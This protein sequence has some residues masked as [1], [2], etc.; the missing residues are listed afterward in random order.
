MSNADRIT[1]QFDG[2]S[3]PCVLENATEVHDALGQVLRGWRIDEVA[4]DAQQPVLTLRRSEIG[5]RIDGDWVQGSLAYTD[6]VDALCAFIAELVRAWVQ[7]NPE[8]LCLHGAAVELG[9]R[10]VVFPSTYRA[11]KSVLTGC[12]AA[13]GAVVYTDDVLPIDPVQGIAR[14]PGIVPRLRLPVPDVLDEPTRRSIDAHTV[15]RGKRY[16]YVDPGSG[17]LASHGAAARIGALVLLDRRPE[18]ETKL[19]PVGRNQILRQVIWQNFARAAPA[20]EILDA[21]HAIVAGAQCY[22]LRYSRADRA[23]ALL[24]DAASSWS[25]MAEPAPKKAGVARV[26]REGAK[27]PGGDDRVGCYRRAE[28]IHERRVDGECFLADEEGARIHHLNPIGSAIWHMLEEPASIDDLVGTLVEAFPEVK[29][30][31]LREDVSAFVSRI[32]ERG[33]LHASSESSRASK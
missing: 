16:A 33:L 13:A 24:M 15:V 18:T 9:E 27:A 25:P 6:P 21:L 20:P 30:E 12:L 5:Y 32:A 29:A 31:Q 4:G 23:A 22:R 7:P 8:L 2:L 19:L 10:L 17:L 1:L 14:A 11:G 26:R 3:R 28:G